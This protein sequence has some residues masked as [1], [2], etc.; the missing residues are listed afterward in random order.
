MAT[1][2]PELVYEHLEHIAEVDPAEGASYRQEAFEVITDESVS[3]QWQ[4]AICD[5]LNEVNHEL[6]FSQTGK[7]E[8]Y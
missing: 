3:P 1:L 6:T 8:S 5:R 4:T 7:E 2:P